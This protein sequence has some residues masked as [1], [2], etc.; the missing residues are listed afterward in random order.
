MASDLDTVRALRALFNDLPRAP[1]GLSHQETMNWI[2]QSMADFEGGEMAYTLEHITRNAMLD[3]VLRFREDGHLQDDQAFEA[4]LQQLAQP[5]GR[6]IFMDQ[7]IQAQ[8]SVDAASRLINRAKRPLSGPD[9]LFGFDADDI[10]RFV[11]AQPRGP[12]PLFAEF[13]ARQDVQQL[14]VF[15][16]PPEAV[17][18]FEWGFVVETHG[19]WNVYIAQ[20]W[21]KGTVGYFHR[22]M[23]AWQMEISTQP[24]GTIISPPPLPHGMSVD[25][26]IG[27]FSAFTLD[28][29]GYLQDATVRR[30]MGETFLARIL[31][32]MAGRAVDD[33]YDFPG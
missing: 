4:T 11:A 28:G 21:R 7:C 14:G 31:P 5:E 17:Y 32:Y 26:G 30:W 29:G 27:H 33:D 23:N 25:D 3:I 18:E 12:G 8:K 20:V 2:R 15:D 6:K 22:F 19:S 10:Q 24:D 16:E 9:P 13:V 1:Q